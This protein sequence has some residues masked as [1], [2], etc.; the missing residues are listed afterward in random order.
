LAGLIAGVVGLI[1]KITLGGIWA[2]I[3]YVVVG[4]GLVIGVYTWV[5]VVVM[6]QKSLYLDLLRQVFHAE[7]FQIVPERSGHLNQ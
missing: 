5:L 7:R 3:P 2:P 1:V 6:D 4:A